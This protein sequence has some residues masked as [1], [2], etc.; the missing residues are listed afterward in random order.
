MLCEMYNYIQST[1]GQSIEIV[2]ISSDRDDRSFQEYFAKMPWLAVPYQSG[3]FQQ[4]TISMR[5]VKEN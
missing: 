1:L 5:L 3:V 4:Q 2:Y